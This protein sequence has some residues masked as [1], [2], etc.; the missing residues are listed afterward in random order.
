MATPCDLKISAILLKKFHPA[1]LNIS[2]TIGLS[3]IK[4]TEH[5]SNCLLQYIPYIIRINNER[6]KS[7]NAY[8]IKRSWED[9]NSKYTT[10]NLEIASNILI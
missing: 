1:I 9:N 2:S 6:R 7:K 4:F 3:Q 8:N 5:S 10:T